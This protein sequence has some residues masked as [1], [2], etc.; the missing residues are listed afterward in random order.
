MKI[1]T[2]SEEPRRSIAD[3]ILTV[4][5]L[6]VSGSNYLLTPENGKYW[7]FEIDL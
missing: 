2:D 6:K 4:F 1:D 3:S 7:S 5:D